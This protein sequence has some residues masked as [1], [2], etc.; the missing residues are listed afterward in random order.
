MSALTDR[1]LELQSRLIES[2]PIWHVS[3]FHH[4]RPEWCD[5]HPELASRLLGLDDASAQHLIDDPAAASAWLAPMLDGVRHLQGLTEL[6]A[7]NQ[8]TLPDARTQLDWSIPGRKR[9]QI[10]AFVASMPQA[11]TPLL[12]WCSG[13]GHLGRWVAHCDQQPVVS[14]ELDTALCEQASQLAGRAQLDQ[15]VIC[16]DALHEASKSNVRGRTV[17]ALHACG[18]LHRTLIKSAGQDGASGYRI[19]PCCYHKWADDH[20]QP[21]SHLAS[22]TLD[23]RALRLA[24]TETVTARSHDRRRLIRDQAWKLGFVALRDELQGQAERS[25]KPVPTA[26][27]QTDFKTFCRRLAA[28]E[29]LQLP[30]QIDWQHWEATGERRRH[31]M[32]RLEIAR[33]AFRRALEIWLLL[34]MTLALEEAG[35]AVQTGQFCDRRLTPRNIMLMADANG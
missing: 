34:D 17:L 8:R 16:A 7:L 28:R 13:K 32:I 5:H 35:F 33:Q 25:F 9:D 6:P 30:A 26:W 11:G 18:E 20:Y 31:D 10:K 22:L 19:A 21:L 14:L 23:Q 29:N 15:Q 2:A 12:E 27:L 24:V 4:P 1:F 3:L